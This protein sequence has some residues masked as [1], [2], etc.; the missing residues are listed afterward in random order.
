[1]INAILMVIRGII[2]REAGYLVLGIAVIMMLVIA[3]V[4][5]G[6]L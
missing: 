6:H 2:T 5:H 1:M 4:I 3:V